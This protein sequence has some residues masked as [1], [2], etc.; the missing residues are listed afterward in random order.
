MQVL[1]FIVLFA[2][3]VFAGAAIYVSFIEHPAR[4]SL[5]AERALAEFRPS[6]KRGAVMQASLAA[7]GGG[8]GL[9]VSIMNNNFHWGVGGALLLSG[10]PY[11]FAAIMAINA[12][13]MDTANP[14]DGAEAEVL[15]RRWGQRHA[16]RTAL[17]VSAFVLMLMAVF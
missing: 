14:P 9:A 7:I 1:S 2:T 17:G 3:G 16:V 6:Y 13:L 11:T 15:L 10:I 8:G 5:G 4:M 12:R